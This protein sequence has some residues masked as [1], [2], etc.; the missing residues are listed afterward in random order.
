LK[1]LLVSVFLQ[2]DVTNGNWKRD[3][4]VTTAVHYMLAGVLP[5]MLITSNSKTLS[6]TPL[7]LIAFDLVGSILI[8][9]SL[10]MV[11]PYLVQKF[12]KS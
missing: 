2:K 1:N 7:A 11:L 3:E 5:L 6:H 4:I 10:Y 9:W 8:G 12:M